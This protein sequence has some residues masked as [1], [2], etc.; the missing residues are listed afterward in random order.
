[1]QVVEAV[2]IVKVVKNRP[3]SSALCPLSSDHMPHAFSNP[4]FEVRK[5]LI[6]T[7]FSR[8]LVSIQVKTAGNMKRA[9]RRQVRMPR[10]VTQPMLRRP[11]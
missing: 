5:V 9:P 4:Q 3:L 10:A 1:M 7:P 2:E 11:G 6:Y 8:R